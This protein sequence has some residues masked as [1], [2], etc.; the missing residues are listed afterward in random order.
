MKTK[1]YLQQ[2]QK[3]DIVINQKLQELNDELQEQLKILPSIEE[4]L[5]FLEKKDG[6]IQTLKDENQ[7]WKELSEKLNNES[8]LLQRQN[9]ELLKFRN[10]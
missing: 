2:L 5:D 7:L 9:E 10:G 8:R 3:L 6:E 4:L 1:E